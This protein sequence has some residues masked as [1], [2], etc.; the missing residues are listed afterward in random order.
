MVCFGSAWALVLMEALC[1]GV[2]A[3]GAAALQPLVAERPPFEY[4]LREGADGR[5]SLLRV[6]SSPVRW[7]GWE[8]W[9]EELSYPALTFH[10]GGINDAIRG[11]VPPEGVPA[12]VS[13]GGEELYLFGVMF[14]GDCMLASYGLPPN[15]FG[16]VLDPRVLVCFGAGG[17]G[18]LWS[19]DFSEYMHAPHQV[20]DSSFTVQAVRWAEVRDGVLYVSHSHRTYSA[21]S[22]GLNA[23]VTAIDLSNMDLLWRSRPLVCNS[24]NFVVLGNT[25]ICGYGFTN[26][27]DYVYLLDR[28]TGEVYDYVIVDSA[29][30]YL[31][32]LGSY[33]YVRCH[34]EDYVMEIRSSG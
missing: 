18:P 1:G 8:G 15:R 9:F 29:P 2:R 24:H 12:T 32:A 6:E 19:V 22:G 28:E 10:N 31:A 16:V 27:D 34:N 7:A 11:D 21:S 30:E 4:T 3:G 5:I 33:L 17:R 13:V 23:Y 25:I 20:E 14:S 26:E